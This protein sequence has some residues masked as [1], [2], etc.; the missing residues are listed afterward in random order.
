MDRELSLYLVVLFAAILT[1]ACESNGCFEKGG[2]E[3]IE[4]IPVTARIVTI[5]DVFDALMSDRA[6]KDAWNETSVLEYIE[7]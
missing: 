3:E 6:Y 1:L 7:K 2:T 4:E 5:A